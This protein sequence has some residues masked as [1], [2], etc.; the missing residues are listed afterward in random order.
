MKKKKAE[1]GKAKEE[2]E[3]RRRHEEEEATYHEKEKG[4]AV[5]ERHEEGPLRK[6]GWWCK[7]PRN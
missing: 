7:D 6:E 3:G 2:E 4:R 1:E 5:K